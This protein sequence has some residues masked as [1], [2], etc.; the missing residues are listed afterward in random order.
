L[1]DHFILKQNVVVLG[2]PSI[3]TTPFSGGIAQSLHALGA[4]A[5]EPGNPFGAAGN[6]F[7]DA[8]PA[9]APAPAP[10]HSAETAAPGDPFAAS[11]AASASG[12][13]SEPAPAAGN[14]FGDAASAA[15][16]SA[17]SASPS[18]EA[19]TEEDGPFVDL[20]VGVV[21]AGLCPHLGRRLSQLPIW[22]F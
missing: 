5:A 18:R 9:P 2:L 22:M 10:G 15:A 12:I 20:K 11:S 13:P 8:A 21:R 3:Q 4:M 16:A 19:V 6:P 17:S 7:G 14:P 1:Q